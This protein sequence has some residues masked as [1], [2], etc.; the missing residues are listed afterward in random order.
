VTPARSFQNATGA[1]E[2]DTGKASFTTDGER[3]MYEIKDEPGDC[4]RPLR[5]FDMDTLT[6][7]ATREGNMDLAERVLRQ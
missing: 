4:R 6:I 1:I 3:K 7:P 5:H 2:F